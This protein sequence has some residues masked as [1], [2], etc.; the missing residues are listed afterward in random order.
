MIEAIAASFKTKLTG[1]ATL[2]TKLGGTASDKKIYNTL[3]RPNA[4]VPYIVWG[5]LTDTPEGTFADVAKIE[6]VP[7]YLN[8]FSSTSIEHLFEIVDLIIAAMDDATLT[9]A[10]YTCMECLREF[11]SNVLYDDSTKIYQIS[12]RYRVLACKN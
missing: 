11:I 2:Q 12:M 8:V 5:L 3:A 4:T 1:D 6:H 10:G 9:I 7:F